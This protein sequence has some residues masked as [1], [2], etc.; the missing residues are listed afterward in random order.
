MG[1]GHRGIIAL[2]LE[3][4]DAAHD[5]FQDAEDTLSHLYSKIFQVM[6]SHLIPLKQYPKNASNAKVNTVFVYTQ[7]IF[8]CKSAWQRGFPK[9]SSQRTLDHLQ[10]AFGKQRLKALRTLSQ[11]HT[12]PDVC[13][14]G[15][16][17]ETSTKLL[18]ANAVCFM[19][20]LSAKLWHMTNT[21]KTFQR[22]SCKISGV[23]DG[24]S[25]SY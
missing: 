5:N 25:W 16:Q 14:N 15:V 7:L 11:W 3:L 23:I 19:C 18:C 4:E 22:L 24:P 1:E 9:T 21:W 13:K 10:F 17:G 8:R 6:N 2:F 12:E 20:K